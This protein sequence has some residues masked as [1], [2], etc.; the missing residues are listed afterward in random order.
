MLPREVEV[1]MFTKRGRSQRA[2]SAGP[3]SLGEAGRGSSCALQSYPAQG[4]PL[5]LVRQ[6]PPRRHGWEAGIRTQQLL[7]GEPRCTG[8]GRDPKNKGS[9]WR[10]WLGAK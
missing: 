5:C 1:E 9:G 10:Q 4:P 6:E 8:T 2:G 7:R 3:G